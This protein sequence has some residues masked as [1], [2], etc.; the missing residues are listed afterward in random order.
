MRADS[1]SIEQA[2]SL[3]VV[4]RLQHLYVSLEGRDMIIDM[5]HVNDKGNFWCAA[6][7]QPT[8]IGVWKAL[9]RNTLRNL[10]MKA[11]KRAGMG[12]MTTNEQLAPLRFANGPQKMSRR[13][14]ERWAN[15][16]SSKRISVS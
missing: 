12:D 9:A 5:K 14:L 1:W 6:G 10:V 13:E 11:V 16:I 15:Q 4:T 7:A 8:T 3:C 2:Q